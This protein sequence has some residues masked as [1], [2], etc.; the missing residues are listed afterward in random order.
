MSIFV[1]PNA[2]KKLSLEQI[3]NTWYVF[4]TV[5]SVDGIEKTDHSNESRWLIHLPKSPV[6]VTT[7]RVT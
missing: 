4:I 6:T 1:E 7:P 5:E 2:K 3:L